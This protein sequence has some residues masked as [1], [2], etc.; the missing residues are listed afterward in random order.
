MADALLSAKERFAGGF[1]CAQSVFSAYA[2]SFGIS[3][4]IAL[5]MAAPLGGGMG[6][7]GEICGALSGALMVLGLQFGEARPEGKDE[8]Y[9]ITREFVEQFRAQHGAVR[10]S[11]LMGH[12]I[13]TP[14]GLQA[15]RSENKSNELCPSL[16]ND[17][18]KALEEYLGEHPTR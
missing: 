13:S 10:C 2:E 15:A 4:E 17:T 5:R 18:A 14:A 3:T 11:D 8:I 12:D 16:V 7:E 1:N 9:R 6:R